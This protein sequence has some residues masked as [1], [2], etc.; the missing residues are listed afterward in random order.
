VTLV[1][2][3]FT[4]LRESSDQLE[5]I[6]SQVREQTIEL[7]ACRSA[8]LTASFPSCRADFMTRMGGWGIAQRCPSMANTGAPLRYAPA[9]RHPFSLA[10]ALQLCAIVARPGLS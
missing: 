6:V 9:T 2:A 8:L 4:R 7:P 3:S 5:R 10:A 1:V